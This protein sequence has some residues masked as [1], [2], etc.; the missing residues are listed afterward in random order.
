MVDPNPLAFASDDF[1]GFVRSRRH[2]Y[3]FNMVSDGPTVHEQIA[4]GLIEHPAKKGLR[5]NILVTAVEVGGSIAL[6]HLAQWMGAS[7]VVSYL[8]GSIG[9]VVGGIMVWAKARKFS[10][11][12]AAIFS[13][14]ALSAAIALIGSHTPK[15]LLYKDCAVTALIG[16]IFLGSCVLVHKPVVFY[17]AQRYG[18]DG[19]HDGMA[20]FDRMWELYRDFRTGVYVISYL[21]AAL[22]LIQAAGTAL[23]IGHSR[24][25]TAYNYDQSLPLAATGLGIVGSIA[26]GR[27]FAKRGKAGGAGANAAPLAD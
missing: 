15:V 24:Y 23:I 25:S 4:Q 5:F 22:F 26:I 3:V 17:M 18:T 10:G 14:T 2:T 7:D 16:L 20:I 8:I 13:F 11:A 12:S 27:Y 19:T 6:F 1:A 21:W 9:P